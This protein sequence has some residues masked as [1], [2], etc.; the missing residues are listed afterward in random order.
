VTL[1]ASKDDILMYVR[2]KIKT[3][4]G[5]IDMSDDFTDEIISSIRS[6][7]DGM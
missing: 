7:S 5:G 6:T 4:D 1:E 2:D 3:D